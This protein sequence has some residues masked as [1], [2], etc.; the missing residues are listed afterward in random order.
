MRCL[1]ALV[2]AAWA[3]LAEADAG[4]STLQ[5]VQVLFRHGERTPVLV[6]PTDPHR[7]HWLEQGLGQLTGRGKRMQYELGQFLRRRY[8]D[9]LPAQY[10]VNYTV[11]RSS[12]VDRTLMSAQANLAGLY[13]PQGRDVWNPD[14][15]WQPIPVHTKPTS[16]DLLLSF[17]TSC[18]RYELELRRLMATPELRRV[19][20]KNRQLYD[21]VSQHCGVE[22][23]DLAT[24][25][26]IYDLLLV[27]SDQNMT[28]PAW[29]TA[30][31]PPYNRTVY[32]DLLRPLN[33]LAFNLLSYDAPLKRL[34]GGALLGRLA[35]LL[36]QK[37]AGSLQPAGR[38]LFM[39]SGHDADVAALLGTLGVYNG[40]APPLA[41]CVIVELHRAPSGAFFVRLFY[42]NDTT[43]A[44]YRLQVPGCIDDCPWEAFRDLAA[45]VTPADGAAECAAPAGGMPSGQQVTVIALAVT[46]ALL[47][48]LCTIGAV[49]FGRRRRQMQAYSHFGEIPT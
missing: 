40:L 33:E 19:D 39:Y 4:N 5:M 2:L 6:C 30:V 12:D 10:H 28:L 26:L 23:R 29:A 45:R 43:V 25:A 42:R 15:H 20:A 49:I 27:E 16:E 24:L 14:L 32:P 3:G 18:A 44:P 13:P 17:L 34:G 8:A 7:D 1:V 31:L 46:L 47:L 9:F 35:E 48:V 21:H 37:V 41:S 11:V 22:V 38:R 36:R